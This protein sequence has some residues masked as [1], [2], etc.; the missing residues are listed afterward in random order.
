MSLTVYGAMKLNSLKNFKLI[1]GQLGIDREITRTAILDYEFSV[2]LA[3]E[4]ANQFAHG[5]FILSSMLYAHHDEAA[6]LSAVKKLI[7]LDVSALAIKTVFFKELPAS[8]CALANEER[9]PIFLFDNSVF[10]EDVISEISESLK[11]SY[12]ISQIESKLDTLIYRDLFREDIRKIS[13]ALN[14][15]FRKN[16][17]VFYGKPLDTHALL[18]VKHIYEA[19]QRNKFR[20]SENLIAGYRNG[21]LLFI[22]D[23]LG[24]LSI[25]KARLEDNLIY[26]GLSKAS[27]SFGHSNVYDAL[28]GLSMAVREAVWAQKASEAF[29][30]SLKSFEDIGIYR[31]L[32]PH[33][34]S[35]WS[36]QYQQTFIE[37]LQKKDAETGTELIKT[38]IAFITCEGNL[39]KTS[40]ALFVHENTVRYRIKNIHA[41]L[42]PDTNAPAFYEQLSAAI[43]L[44]VLKCQN[45]CI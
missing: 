16:V 2:N 35:I 3:E 27:F 44:H 1:C 40:E 29:P 8:V 26:C 21:L 20:G 39:K 18:S 6:L 7:E 14:R 41:L 42:C 34:D 37:P 12:Q 43:R 28:E 32:L 33:Q 22:S 24:D 13:M 10:F 17:V 38:A 25:Y 11:T 31:L 9:F 19:Y 45:R 23:D 36:D 30:T 4:F 15:D 5:E